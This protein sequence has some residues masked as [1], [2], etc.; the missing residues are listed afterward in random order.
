MSL[1][2]P[3]EDKFNFN[4][5]KGNVPRS[6][7]NVSKYSKLTGTRRFHEMGLAQYEETRGDANE[8]YVLLKKNDGSFV[9][10]NYSWDG[11]GWS[12]REIDSCTD[13]NTIK[14]RFKEL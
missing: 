2:S 13:Y 14:E 11:Y 7:D 6:G 12:M 10:K 3:V 5:L 4:E 8:C 9:V 1:K